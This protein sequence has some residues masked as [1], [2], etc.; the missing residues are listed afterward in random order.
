[1]QIG[2]RGNDGF[3]EPRLDEAVTRWTCRAIATSVLKR[4]RLLV[5]LLISRDLV[6]EEA[7]IRRSTIMRCG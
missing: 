1:M 4:R 7:E 2:A 6:S 3:R 5:S